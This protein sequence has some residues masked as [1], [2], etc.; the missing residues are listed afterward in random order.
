MVVFL[1][2]E[3]AID[4]HHGSALKLRSTCRRS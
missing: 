2:K 1:R 3:A 4:C